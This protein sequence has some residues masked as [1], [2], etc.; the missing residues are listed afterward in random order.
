M[1]IEEIFRVELEKAFNQLLE[2]ELDCFLGDSIIVQAVRYSGGEVCDFME[3]GA[4][5]IFVDN[6][7]SN[8]ENNAIYAARYIVTVIDKL[9]NIPK[10]LL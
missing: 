2:I 5:T 1:S 9:L 6:E 8:A 4:L 3:D 7:H 10:I